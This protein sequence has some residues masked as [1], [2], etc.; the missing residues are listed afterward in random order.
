MRLLITIV[1][2]SAYCTRALAQ[3]TIWVNEGYKRYMHRENKVW[4]FNNHLKDGY[5][6]SYD[7]KEEYKQFPSS[8]VLI[9]NGLKN[10]RE[11]HYYFRDT[12]RY[13]DANWAQGVRNGE[14]IGYHSN[15]NVEHRVIYKNGVV[16]GP[17]VIYSENGKIVYK[18]SIKHGFKDSIWTYYYDEKCLKDTERISSQYR[19]VNNKM[20]LLN[21]WTKDGRQT[22]GNG[23]SIVIDTADEYYE[24]GVLTGKTI[25]DQNKHP[26][27]R[28]IG[29]NDTYDEQIKKAGKLVSRYRI[30]EYGNKFSSAWSYPHADH[31]DTIGCCTSIDSYHDFPVVEMLFSDIPERNNHWL[32]TFANGVVA[33]DGYY[34]EGVRFGQWNWHYKNGQPRTSADYSNN[35]WHHYDSIGHEVNNTLRTEYLTLLTDHF[36]FVNRSIN[37]RKVVFSSRPM[38]MVTPKLV[39]GFDNTVEQIDYLECG[40]DISYDVLK[41]H[42]IAD[43]LTL[44]YKTKKGVK[45]YHFRIISGNDEEMVLER[46][47]HEQP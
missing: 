8:G 19:F 13:L 40:K 47:K 16:D 39:F 4:T 42:I 44:D 43:K 29:N 33:Y 25:F 3:D 36:W 21:S 27:Y 7:S 23:N 34:K 17:F 15:G 46:L 22:V 20:L 45:T 28:R 10:G 37:K 31:I 6:R 18:G 26:K 12:L 41:W 32:M 30:D 2:F 38:L 14:E 35:E 1:L 24:N 11:S 5:Y 9:V